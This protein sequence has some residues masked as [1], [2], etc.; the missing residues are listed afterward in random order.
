[1]KH[2]GKEKVPYKI[3]NPLIEEMLNKIVKRI[4]NTVHPK[5]IILFG[6]AARGE[7]GPDSDF[8]LLII[9]PSGMH[10]RRTAQRIYR[11]LI[12]VGFASDIIVV[13]EDDIEKY[14]DSIGMVIQPA[15]KEGRV[16]YAA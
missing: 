2:K 14:K 3:E 8:D 13:T 6:S 11:N 12:G 9:V 4:I 16:L 10:R 1:M 7:M 5:K 15:L